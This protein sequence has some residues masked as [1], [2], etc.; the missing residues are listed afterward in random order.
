MKSPIDK[1]EVL[2]RLN[3][4]W[5]NLSSSLA[6]SAPENYNLHINTF[7]DKVVVLVEELIEWRCD[8]DCGHC[9][10]GADDDEYE[11]CR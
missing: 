5:E 9:R 6:F 11:L 3:H 7:M 10:E 2:A 4:D 1:E 8:W